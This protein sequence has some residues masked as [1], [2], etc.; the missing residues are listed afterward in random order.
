MSSTGDCVAMD[1]CPGGGRVLPVILG[2][3]GSSAS[4]NAARWAAYI[5]GALHAP[6]LVVHV[7]SLPGHRHASG[8]RPWFHG[9]RLPDPDQVPDAAVV[10]RRTALIIG[11]CSA[12][13]VAEPATEIATGSATAV[14]VERSRRAR[15][16][17]VGAQTA[18]GERRTGPT[19]TGVVARAYSPVA[20]WRG[21]PGHPIPRERPVV[22]AFDGSE[23]TLPALVQGFE[24]AEA[25]GAGLE[26]VRP[27][28]DMPGGR[29]GAAALAPPAGIARAPAGMAR[30][31]PAV[32]SS[33]TTVSG[34]PAHVLA[35]RS[36]TAQLLVVGDRRA[37]GASVAP[38]P[39]VM[40]LLHHSKCPVLVCR[41]R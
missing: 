29:Y 18:F 38:G 6:L 24:L 34:S 39:T 26:V 22:V 41:P 20:V 23:S 33:E 30:E 27:R 21:M 2:T 12:P 10:V 14:L 17:V 13:A 8:A 35:R 16:L 32:R 37:T 3:D 1:E 4:L 31:H 40:F 36:A 11:T 15:M 25:L 19:T 9:P 7:L 28:W 5:A